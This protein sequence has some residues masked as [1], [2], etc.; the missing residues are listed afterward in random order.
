[1]RA[2]VVR[3]FGPVETASIGEMPK[4][5]PRAN[6]VL[7]E[8]RATAANYV[9]LLVIGGKY[10]F[11]PERPFVPG[12]LPVGVVAAVGDAVTGLRAGDRVLAMAEHGGYAEYVAIAESQCHRLP[13]AMSFVDAAATA[14]V[15]D[16]SWMA[17]RERARYQAG[18]TVLVLGASGGVGLAS[19]QLAKALGAKVLAGVASPDKHAM[20]REAGADAIIDL[21]R[22]NLREAL[23]EQVYAHTQGK[24]ADI[25]LDPVG[26]DIF[27]AAL[28][29]LAWCGRLVVIGFAAGRIPTIQ[30]NY[31]LVKNIEVSGLQISDY[32]KRR[33][34]L[35]AACFAEVFAL[36]EQGKLKPLPATVYP[37]EQFKTAL[38]AI[39]D[40]KVRGRIILTQGKGE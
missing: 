36:H 25:I 19:V 23:R 37:I 28:R 35:L 22:D 12:K 1:M 20:V 8:I 11:L 9:D 40:R 38:H 31:L 27:D 2:V 21:A 17:L 14:L 24:G 7:V 39:Q 34:D 13:A 5:A 18:E 29:A 15:Y 26:G 3:E 6:E 30:A 32:R 10:Q 4:P 33:P 16:T